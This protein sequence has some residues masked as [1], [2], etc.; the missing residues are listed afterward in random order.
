L[1]PTCGVRYERTKQ[2]CSTCARSRPKPRVPAHAKTLRDDP[3]ETYIQAAKDIHGVTDESCC[4]CEKPRNAERR[5]DRDHGHL[6]GDPSYGKPRGLACV[7][8]NKIMVRELDL[9]R[10]R[11]VVAYLERVDIWYRLKASKC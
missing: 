6:K 11:L 5:H 10:A 8:C 7:S 4:V 2:K 3:Y 1:C 9:L